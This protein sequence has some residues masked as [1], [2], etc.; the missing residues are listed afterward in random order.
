[1][2][3]NESHLQEYL[4]HR[5]V[6]SDLI[7]WMVVCLAEPAPLLLHH[8]LLHHPASLPRVY[9]VTLPLFISPALSHPTI[10]ISLQN[11]LNS[12][13]KG[14]LA[15]KGFS[16]NLRTPFEALFL[17]SPFYSNPEYFVFLPA[18]CF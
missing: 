2:K 12:S 14:M 15:I 8:L 6:Q 3:W 1:M 4:K 13:I 5:S 10:L 17:I 9:S 18:P 7:V 11:I 16:T